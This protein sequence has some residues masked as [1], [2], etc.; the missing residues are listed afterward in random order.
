MS[1]QP[2][3]YGVNWPPTSSRTFL[4]LSLLGLTAIG[5]GGSTGPAGMQD[6][7]CPPASEAEMV[8]FEGVY[9]LTAFTRNNG[10]CSAEGP[11]VLDQQMERMFFCKQE[12]FLGRQALTLLSCTDPVNCHDKASKLGTGIGPAAFILENFSCRAGDASVS[13]RIA[14]TGYGGS[15]GMCHEPF[16]KDVAAT[17]SADR[18]L[19]V[20]S[21]KAIGDDYAQMNGYCT[22]EGGISNSIGK[23]C[24]V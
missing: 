23:P 19:V 5:C 18:A 2:L 22:S 8:A 9:E 7:D 11:S 15:D 16:I 4:W 24:S 10:S 17:R 20:E 21:R 12:A 3:L 1:H 14:S 6:V 13:S